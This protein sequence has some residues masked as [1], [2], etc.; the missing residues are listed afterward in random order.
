MFK[1]SYLLAAFKIIT[2]LPYTLVV[3]ALYYLLRQFYPKKVAVL[4]ST[5][6]FL[7]VYVIQVSV[8][9]GGNST[10]MS[11][12]FCLY[13][14]AI[15]YQLFKQGNKYLLAPA[16]FSIAATPLI[17]AIPAMVFIY[18]GGLGALF[19]IFY[20]P[21][22]V[23]MT[24]ING[25]LLLIMVTGLLLPFLLNLEIES[26]Q[27]LTAMIKD[28]QQTMTHNRYGEQLL[29]NIW[30][31]FDRIKNR[32]SDNAFVLSILSIVFILIRKRWTALL[33]SA[34]LY[35]L[36]FVLFINSNYWFLPMSEVLYPER[37][38]FFVLICISIVWS[39]FL[40]QSFEKPYI[41]INKIPLH[42]LVI[43]VF[44]I[45]GL[46]QFNVK[47]L[48]NISLN[49]VSFNQEIQESFTWISENIAPDGLIQVSYM[50]SGIWIPAFT[51]RSIVGGHMHFIHHVEN[52]EEKLLA[53]KNKRYLYLTKKDLEFG[54]PI[55]NEKPLGKVVFKNCEV[56]IV[57]LP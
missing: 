40:N 52:C 19:F 53:S 38:A 4:G 7:L 8:S 14:L 30:V 55:L 15:I 50:D 6:P 32:I 56:E 2:T 3:L 43:L 17:H 57:S 54:L 35:A 49:P 51:K 23:K 1:E 46:I 44:S 5:I 28:W 41:Q 26:S 29:E 20:H 22:R 39:E 24:M 10:V 45:L 13:S 37:V 33:L 34:S 18:V 16:S 47:Y 42:Y 25:L 21:D 48:K 27:K 36:L 12:A 31:T 9:W 11:F